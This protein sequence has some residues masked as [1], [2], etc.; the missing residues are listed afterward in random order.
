MVECEAIP[1]GANQL[2][3]VCSLSLYWFICLRLQVEKD[4]LIKTITKWM[5]AADSIRKEMTAN[6]TLY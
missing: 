4:G 2:S 3:S 6:L 5:E 1:C